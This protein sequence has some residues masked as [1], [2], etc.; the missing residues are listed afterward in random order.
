MTFD[1]LPLATALV[2]GWTRV[3][4][5]GLP[6][7]EQAARL[8]EIDSDLWEFEHDPDAPQREWVAMHMLARLLIGVPDDLAW[9]M[10]AGAAAHQAP[11]SALAATG[12]MTG[13]RR[14]SA[15]GLAA[16][17][18][19]VAI[20]AVGWLASS[21]SAPPREPGQRSRR[22][23]WFEQRLPSYAPSSNQRVQ[24]LRNNE[25]LAKMP[26]QRGAAS[27]KARPFDV[28]SAVAVAVA[29]RLGLM[30]PT[31]PAAQTPAAAQGPVFEVASI[32]PNPAGRDA[33]TRQRTLQGGRFVAENMPV[34]LLIGQAFD[35]PAYRL[36]GGPQW[37]WSDAFD[38]NARADSDLLP[39][40]GQRP[41]RGA[42]RALLADRFK[43]VAHIETRQLPMYA[44]V[45]ARSDGRLGPNLTR[46]SRTDCDAIRERVAKEQATDGPSGPPP[47][48]PANGVAPPC[49]AMN[50]VG[51][52][53]IDSGTLER[54]AN[55]LSSELNTRVADRTGLT[56]L[57]NARLTWTPDQS[58]SGALDPGARPTDPDGPAL[59][60]AVQEQ[61]GLKL[62]KT[63][64]PVDVL[65]IDRIERPTPN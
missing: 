30:T 46:S 52:F 28:V 47:P 18:H 6:R 16:T 17:I 1:P 56:G 55:Y 29:V 34:A 49:G 3:Y 2:R 33:P 41:L 57:F 31:Q 22:Q 12:T 53:A 58:P 62:Q 5:R 63:T 59:F 43:L 51:T 64:G 60:T 42:L 61:L 37:I 21:N 32:K 54:L 15:F 23:P 40:D 9:R 20:S 65:I 10:D 27:G 50:G 24:R 11:V 48:P 19:I 8:A 39:A 4:T 36:T 45:L 14:A 25:P 38:I 26:L 7:A 44:L 13:P 35:L